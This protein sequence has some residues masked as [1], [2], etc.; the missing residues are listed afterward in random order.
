MRAGLLRYKDAL[1]ASGVKFIGLPDAL[2]LGEKI[3]PN[4][5]R[6]IPIEFKSTHNLLVPFEINTIVPRYNQAYE[7]GGPTRTWSNIGQPLSQLFAYMYSNNSRCGVLSS[8]TRTYFLYVNEEHH[9]P[10]ISDAW[11]IGEENYLRAWSYFFK[12]ASTAE[13]WT[14]LPDN[15]NMHPP[16]NNR[17]QR[18]KGVRSGNNNDEDNDPSSSADPGALS[19]RRTLT[20]FTKSPSSVI[21]LV[22]CEEI[23]LL[24]QLGRGNHQVRLA[25]WRGQEIA[26]KC[27]DMFK[28]YKWFE[29]EVRAY[30]HLKD[31]WGELVPKPYFISDLYGSIALLGMQLGR[32]PNSSDENFASERDRLFSKLVNQHGFDHLDTDRGNVIYIP[33]GQ[34]KERLV[35][36]DL[37]SHEIFEEKRSRVA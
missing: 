32:D 6:V 30:E 25:R 10:L 34:G 19:S 35:A 29:S 4:K 9:V 20:T 2:L 28:D 3:E 5:H 15:W 33:D 21:P 36:M 18:N 1:G 27:F 23:E 17:D 7:S 24:D 14:I 12:V 16:G 8:G 37:E 26:V 11:L 31:E 13:P 22:Y